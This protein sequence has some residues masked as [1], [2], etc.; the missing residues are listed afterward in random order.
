M[1]FEAHV[2][3]GED[4]VQTPCSGIYNTVNAIKFTPNESI[5]SFATD[6]TTCE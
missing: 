2:G 1:S 4:R 5:S 3:C 6:S